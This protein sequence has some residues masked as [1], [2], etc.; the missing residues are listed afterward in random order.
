MKISHL[1]KNQRLSNGVLAYLN[2]LGLELNYYFEKSIDDSAAEEWD[3]SR[4]FVETICLALERY[5][6]D[7]L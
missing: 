3:E 2:R 5:A 7:V 1:Q 6:Y 4:F